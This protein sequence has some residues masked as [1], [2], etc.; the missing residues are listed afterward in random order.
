MILYDMS[1]IDGHIF[2]IKTE[3]RLVAA[4]SWGR[5]EQAETADQYMVPFWGNEN[6][7]NQMTVRVAHF[8][9]YAKSH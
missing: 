6:V 7:P 8:H 2:L 5:V 3:S 9:E 1:K 4:W